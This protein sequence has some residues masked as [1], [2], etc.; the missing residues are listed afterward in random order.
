MIELKNQTKV[1]TQLLE[2]NQNLR[3]QMMEMM[4]KIDQ[5]MNI[6]QSQQNELNQL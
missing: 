2:D 4:K 1:K 5:L 3:L 6:T